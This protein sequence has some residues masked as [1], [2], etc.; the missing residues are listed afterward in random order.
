MENFVK[1]EFNDGGPIFPHSKKNFFVCVRGN[2]GVG[3]AI[4][5]SLSLSSMY[6]LQ[7]EEKRIT[8]QLTQLFPLLRREC[9]NKNRPPPSV[10]RTINADILLFLFALQAYALHLKTK[11]FTK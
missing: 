8:I 5:P 11:S 7:A 9:H 10:S 4:K 6:A 2:G 1:M 3:G